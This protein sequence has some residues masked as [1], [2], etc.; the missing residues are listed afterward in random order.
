MSPRLTRTANPRIAS[1]SRESRT[2]TATRY[3]I[4]R[5]FRPPVAVRVTVER[6]RPVRVAIDRRGMPGGH[7][8]QAAGPWRTSGAWWDASSMA[9]GSR[10]VGRRAQRWLGL[11]PL[12]RSDRRRW[13]LEGDPR[14]IASC[15]SN[16]TPRPPFLSSMAPRCPK[17]SSSARRRSAIRRSRC[18]IATACTAPRAFISRPSAPGSRR[19]SA[20]S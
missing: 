20:P 17:R 12:P 9:M 10:R 18:S 6:G 5:R 11:P 13:F 14:L 15:T 1:R 16:C 19:S 3:L 8:E 4:L 7:V 2:A